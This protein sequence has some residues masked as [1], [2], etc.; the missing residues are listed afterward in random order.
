MGMISIVNYAAWKRARD[1]AAALFADDF[2]RADSASTLGANWTVAGSLVWGTQSNKAY[3]PTISAFGMATHDCG[4]ADIDYTVDVELNSTADSSRGLVTFR[5]DG[6]TNNRWS[7]GLDGL[8]AKLQLIK[9][10]AGTATTVQEPAFSAT[11]G[12]LY[13]IRVVA[14]LSAVTVYVNGVSTLTGTDDTPLLS[15]TS[16]GIAASRKAS[17]SGS[18]RFDNI[19]IMRAA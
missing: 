11:L 10:V 17:A 9:I 12:L 16:H 6:T 8:L 15:L 3:A 7:V 4:E 2:N 13:T 1:A 14:K 18:P 5:S 19:K